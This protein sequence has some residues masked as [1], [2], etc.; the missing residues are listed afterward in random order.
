MTKV[1]LSS[2]FQMKIPRQ[3][4]SKLVQSWSKFATDQA[5]IST[6][7]S[8]TFEPILVTTMLDH[9]YYGINFIYALWA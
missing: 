5:G 2:P 1:F 3:T 9:G 7:G 8:I 6:P 4:G